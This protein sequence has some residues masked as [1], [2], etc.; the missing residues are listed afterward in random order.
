VCAFALKHARA[1]GQSQNMREPG[2]EKLCVDTQCT[3]LQHTPCTHTHIHTNSHAI[4][5]HPP[6]DGRVEAPRAHSPGSRVGGD[7]LHDNG[8]V[9]TQDLRAWLDVN[10]QA[11]VAA[12]KEGGER[13]MLMGS[14]RWQGW[15]SL[16]G[17]RAQ[18]YHGALPYSSSQPCLWLATNAC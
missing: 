3:N 14:R 10:S 5:L 13:D 6:Q 18:S 1:G 11:L 7:A 16:E 17:R 8:S 4:A 12:D 9:G 15:V 2:R